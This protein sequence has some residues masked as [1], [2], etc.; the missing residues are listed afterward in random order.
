MIVIKVS[1]VGLEV[2]VASPDFSKIELDFRDVPHDEPL[3]PIH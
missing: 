2:T 1:I 3:H